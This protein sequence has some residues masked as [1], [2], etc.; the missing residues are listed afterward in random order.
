MET[1]YKGWPGFHHLWKPAFLASNDRV[2]SFNFNERKKLQ[3]HG[4]KIK[5][6]SK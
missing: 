6:G 3:P 4:E 1:F 2:C 5:V